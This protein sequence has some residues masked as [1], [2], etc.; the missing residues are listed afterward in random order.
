MLDS[1]RLD[2]MLYAPYL[3]DSQTNV[4]TILRREEEETERDNRKIQHTDH[5]QPIAKSTTS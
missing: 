4:A 5:V 1:P 3:C 2:L